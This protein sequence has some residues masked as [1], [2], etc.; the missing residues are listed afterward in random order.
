MCSAS[1]TSTARGCAPAHALLAA[2]S[3]HGAPRLPLAG[4]NPPSQRSR[5]T[6]Q[7]RHAPA[8][9]R[10]AHLAAPPATP[11]RA[12]G[13]DARGVPARHH[14]PGPRPRAPPRPAAPARAPV[15]RGRRQVL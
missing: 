2:H 7:T 8:P 12:A 6:L 15:G 4:S 3:S 13:G 1:L 5:P 14:A 11:R 10:P 9:R